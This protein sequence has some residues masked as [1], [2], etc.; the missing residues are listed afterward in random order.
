MVDDL[1]ARHPMPG[2]SQADVEALLGPPDPDPY[3][4]EEQPERTGAHIYRL[5][6]DHLNLDSLWLVI[7]FNAKGLVANAE[8]VSD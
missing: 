1:L 8:V 5:G 6:P 3:L 7:D 2:R 4:L